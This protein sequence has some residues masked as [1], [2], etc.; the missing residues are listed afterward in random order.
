MTSY[1]LVL[2]AKRR[3]TLPA[4]LLRDAELPE[5]KELVAR[6]IGPGRIVLEDP[7]A[8]LGRLQAAVAE[9]KRARKVSASLEAE[10]LETRAQDTERG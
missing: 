3:P 7:R 5:A 4:Q 10:L 1:R 2:D 8:A 9:G 6:V